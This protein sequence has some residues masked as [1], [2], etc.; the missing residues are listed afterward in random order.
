MLYCANKQ[1]LE[2]FM[3]RVP[4][5]NEPYI[6]TRFWGFS[7]HI[8]T[9]VQVQIREGMDTSPQS[10]ILTFSYSVVGLTTLELNFYWLF[11]KLSV[12]TFQPLTVIYKRDN[13]VYNHWGCTSI[14]RP[15]SFPFI[16][17]TITRPSSEY[18]F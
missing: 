15:L 7:G 3:K 4:E 2:E 12:K 1:F 16:S 13:F 10:F 5:L 11:I 18:C 17:L 14:Y 6:P 8:Q 9:I